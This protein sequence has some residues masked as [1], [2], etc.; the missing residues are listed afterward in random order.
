MYLI[1]YLN[2]HF[3]LL[4]KVLIRYQ[5]V[6]AHIHEH[7]SVV[8]WWIMTEKT[9]K[10][11]VLLIIIYLLLQKRSPAWVLLI[12]LEVL[13]IDRYGYFRQ[14]YVVP[15]KWCVG[16]ITRSH[17]VIVLA[18]LP[19]LCFFRGLV[20]PPVAGIQC[21]V[22]ARVLSLCLAIV[23]SHILGI[24][25]HTLISTLTTITLSQFLA[26]SLPNLL[27]KQPQ[28]HPQH[29]PLSFWQTDILH[30]LDVGVYL[31]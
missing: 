2:K 10:N 18:Q 5:E 23:F 14:E 9:A 19:R 25:R 29:S 24:W 31:N 13:F 30:S 7:L 3:Q 26:L 1:R 4:L 27:L 22:P 16:T 6:L 8:F 17:L 11:K 20:A 28:F 15:K 21:L 12:V